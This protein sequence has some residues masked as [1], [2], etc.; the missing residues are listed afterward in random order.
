MHLKAQGDNYILLI[1]KLEENVR[2]ILNFF[3][4]KYDC[5]DP[6]QT[7]LKTR[8]TWWCVVWVMERDQSSYLRSVLL[9]WTLLTSSSSCWILRRT[10]M[11][12]CCRTPNHN[13]SHSTVTLRSSPTS[14]CTYHTHTYTMCE[15]VQNCYL[16]QGSLKISPAH[17][18]AT[19]TGELTVT[20]T[21][22]VSVTGSGV[23]RAGSE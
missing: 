23:S 10:C 6:I 11:C 19:T 9:F 15:S 12:C 5:T 1:L 14:I 8:I 21:C 16:T 3:Y 17:I 18:D 7:Y 22:P 20:S 4:F 13:S 2:T